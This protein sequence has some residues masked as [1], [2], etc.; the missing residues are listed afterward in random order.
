MGAKIKSILKSI[1]YVYIFIVAQVL[2]AFTGIIFFGLDLTT[3]DLT[4]LNVNYLLSSVMD[5]ILQNAITITLIAAI[6]SFLT[7]WLLFAIK[8]KDFFQNCGFKALSTKNSF[9]L[10]ILGIALHFL[11]VLLY[12]IPSLAR[13]S[14]QHDQLLRAIMDNS[15]PLMILLVAGIVAPILEEILFRG[16]ILNEL[17]KNLS[18]KV[19]IIIQAII[20]GLI[21]GNL[22]QGIYAGILGVILGL[23]YYN[24]G[25]LW[26][27]II[28]H[29]SFNSFS[30]IMDKLFKVGELEKGLMVMLTIISG[31]YIL[32]IAK[33]LQKNKNVYQTEQTILAI[34]ETA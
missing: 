23:L 3:M 5:Y 27:P 15:D 2:V 6:L 11:V 7:Y 10:T 33:Y 20:F 16:L 17:K 31:L 9:L 4:A 22:F 28:T 26:A 32:G 29:I 34:K 24:T 13:Y 21:H 18:L 19:S 12:L 1:F 30:I 8:K 25:S 14:S